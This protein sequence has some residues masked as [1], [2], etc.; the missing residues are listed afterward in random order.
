M[1]MLSYIRRS[2]IIGVLSG[3][4]G[5]AGISVEAIAL[6]TVSPTAA[7][8]ASLSDPSGASQLSGQVSVSETAEG[9]AIEATVTN[10]PPGYH[11]FHIHAN[12]SCA[13]NGNAAGG[14]YNPDGVKHGY[15]PQDGFAAAHAGDLGNILIGQN[16]R[17]VYR[18]TISGLTLTN[19]QYA[20]ANHAVIVHANRDDF[21]QP[22]GNAGGRIGCGILAASNP[23]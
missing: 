13:D 8:Q 17:G 12:A 4:I 7:A 18:Q 15:L 21:G 14:H 10:A 2:V 20:V 9:L 23:E 3:L 11:G 19:G 1:N 16:G 22:T 6:P 5:F